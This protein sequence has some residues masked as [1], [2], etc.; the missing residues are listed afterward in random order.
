M[1]GGCRL[2]RSFYARP[3]L[4]VAPE[5]LNKI[6]VGP[7]GVAGRIVEVEAYCGSD[8]P[9]S[10]AYR[11]PTPRTEVMFGPPGHLYVYFS[12]GMHWCANAVVEQP[13]TA[14]AVLIRALSPT[15]GLDEMRARRPAARRAA[16][17]CSG[18]AKLT[19]ALAIEGCHD[20]ADLVTADR[21]VAIVD[22]G[23]GPPE[24]P[25]QS[26][27]IGLSNGR[28][29]PWRWFVGDVI[30]VSHRRGSR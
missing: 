10:H 23:L 3:A 17:L 13:G 4:V 2:D 7:G 18:P 8:D 28:D 15:D 30:D 29:R 14:G 16:D 9:G 19:Q 26:T 27:R 5:L 25:V 24:H 20:G 11:G 6:L 22:D 1:R 21:D 12:Y